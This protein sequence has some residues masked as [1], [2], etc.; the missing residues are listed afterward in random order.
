MLQHVYLA[1]L[2]SLLGRGHSRWAAWPAGAGVTLRG[3]RRR[4]GKRRGDG[5]D[6][7]C[8]TKG[9][10][11]PGRWMGSCGSGHKVV[12]YGW[13]SFLAGAFDWRKGCLKRWCEWGMWSF[14]SCSEKLT[15]KHTAGS[16]LLGTFRTERFQ[17]RSSVC[18]LL[19]RNTNEQGELFFF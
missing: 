1:L 17:Q 12:Q 16:T 3:W 2:A 14:C 9:V 18:L 11:E 19:H 7:Q 6:F 4:A 8:E 5:C 10:D 15:K 13:E